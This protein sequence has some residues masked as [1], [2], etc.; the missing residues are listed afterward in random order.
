[1]FYLIILAGVIFA[2]PGILQVGDLTNIDA[3]MQNLLVLGAGFLL[4]IAYGIAVSIILTVS[5]Y[6]L[7]VD[8]LGPIQA[9]KT[10]YRFFLNNKT[11]VVILWLLTIVVI[12][13]LNFLSTLFAQFEYLS[14]IWSIISTVLSIVVI[15]AVFTIW[16]TFLYMGKTGRV[17]HA[18]AQEDD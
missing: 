10:G 18:G 14:I 2:I 6:A 4:W 1:L 11:A 13:A 8:K 3:I 17:I 7:V 5:Y 16:W 9:L 12:I 15:P